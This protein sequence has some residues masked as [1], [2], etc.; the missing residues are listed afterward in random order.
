M[1]PA[2]SISRQIPTDNIL[3]EISE[4]IYKRDWQL[5]A[6]RLGLTGADISEITRRTSN[7]KDQV[8][9]PTEQSKLNQFTYSI[10]LFDSLA[11]YLH[12]INI[13]LMCKTTTVYQ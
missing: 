9:D 10:R 4:K 6:N 1:E 13:H 2:P 12:Q 7:K 5:V 3:K 11:C 8:Y